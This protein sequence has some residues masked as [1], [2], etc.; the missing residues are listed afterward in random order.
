MRGDSWVV[1]ADAGIFGGQVG[2]TAV[3]LK[4]A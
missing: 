1:W 2:A 3:C 4:A